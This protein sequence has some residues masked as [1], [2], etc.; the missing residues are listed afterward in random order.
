MNRYRKGTLGNFSRIALLIFIAINPIC[1]FAAPKATGSITLQVVSSRTKIKRARSNITFSYT[2]VIF[3]QV[4]GKKLVYECIQK[5]N[6][7]PAMDSGKMY[8][9]DQDG[10]FIYFTMTTPDDPKP[11]AVK[12]KRVGTW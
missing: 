4:E 10:D 2:D 1:A 6:L 3:A 7:C 9:A 5:D 8:T 12:Y 11:F